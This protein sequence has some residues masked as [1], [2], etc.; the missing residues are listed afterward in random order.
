MSTGHHDCYVHG[1]KVM[2]IKTR[3]LCYVLMPI[4]A[5]NE[6]TSLNN[7]PFQSAVASGSKASKTQEG[8]L[9]LGVN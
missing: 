1:I 9:H 3:Y 8:I 6:K 7:K 5:D 4:S 2:L